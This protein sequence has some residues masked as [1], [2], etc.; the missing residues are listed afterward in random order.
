M[1]R[2]AITV[3]E[4]AASPNH[5]TSGVLYGRHNSG[6]MNLPFAYVVLRS[7]D[8]VALV[9][10]GYDQSDFGGEIANAIGVTGWTPPSE[11]LGAVGIRPEDV[12]HVFLTHAHFDHM[13]GLAYFP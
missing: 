13:G 2:Y 1:T 7:S 10:A 5:P 9:D 12:Q 3:L 8:T 11:V 6:S 4:Y